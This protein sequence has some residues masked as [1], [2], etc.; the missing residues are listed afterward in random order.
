MSIHVLDP[1]LRPT[2]ADFIPAYICVAFVIALAA[3]LTWGFP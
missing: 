2:H 3:V 1:R